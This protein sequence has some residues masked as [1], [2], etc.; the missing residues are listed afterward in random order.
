[1]RSQEE[2]LVEKPN[3]IEVLNDVYELRERLGFFKV[4]DKLGNRIKLIER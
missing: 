1:M 4:G 3:L 2:S